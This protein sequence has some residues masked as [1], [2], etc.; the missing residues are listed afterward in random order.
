[1]KPEPENFRDAQD[2]LYVLGRRVRSAIGAHR[3]NTDFNTE[4]Y[5]ALLYR[6]LLDV[7]I[8]HLFPLFAPL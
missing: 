4:A 6:I 3:Q 8:Q 5:D 7:V 2:L 1:M